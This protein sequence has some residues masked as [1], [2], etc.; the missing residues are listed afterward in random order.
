[1][2][3]STSR[4]CRHGSHD[5]IKEGVDNPGLVGIELGQYAWL[6]PIDIAIIALQAGWLRPPYPMQYRS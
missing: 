3:Q 6:N 5:V 4:R 2:R 1:M